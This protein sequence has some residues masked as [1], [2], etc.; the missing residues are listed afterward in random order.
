LTGIANP[1]NVQ[2]GY[3]YDQTGRTTGVTGSGYANVPT[4]AT[5]FSYRAFGLKQ[6][7]YGNNRQ[8]TMNYD[9]RLRMTRWDVAG[10][11]GSDYQYANYGENGGRVTFAG[12]RYDT[13]HALDRS[14]NYDQVG[15]LFV[16][17]TG[18]EA[19]ADSG[20]GGMV[21]ATARIRMG[22]ATMCSAI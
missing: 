15:R 14:Y 1:W 12:S 22:S 19:R 11:I 3:S 6:M 5:G 9:T 10:V 21:E 2:V 4:Y 20:Q 17:R 16:A 7:S 8:L 13:T 18:V